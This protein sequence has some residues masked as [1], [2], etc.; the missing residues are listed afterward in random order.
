M[1][2]NVEIVKHAGLW[3]DMKQIQVLSNHKH[4]T[5]NTQK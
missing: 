3:L 1:S 5:N 2:K 4:K